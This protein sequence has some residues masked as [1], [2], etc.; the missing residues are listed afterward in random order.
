MK[1]QTNI[2]NS[3]GKVTGHFDMTDEKIIITNSN[4]PVVEITDKALIDGINNKNDEAIIQLYDEY[5]LLISEIAALFGV[6][7]HNM[8]KKIKLLDVKTASKQGRR[9]SSYGRVFSDER[10]RHIGE[11]HIGKSPS[12][13]PYERTPEIRQRISQTLKEGYKSGRIVVNKEGLS[14]A[15]RDGKYENPPMGRG[16]QG[17][18]SVSKNAKDKDIYFRSLLELYYIIMLEENP[19]VF[20][21]IYEPIH[22][23]LVDGSTYTPDF[24]VNDNVMIELKPSNHMKWR[25]DSQNNRFENEISGAKQYCDENGIEFKLIYDMDIG[26]ETKSYKKYLLSNPEIINKYNIRFNKPLKMDK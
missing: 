25:K 6:N 10:R 15:W 12:T 24:L 5:T 18:I 22:I 16:I 23:K 1:Y 26:F 17:Y 13:P 14:Q 2:K 11:S 8:N 19:D 7:Y 9:N 3:S 21:I 4:K 20:K